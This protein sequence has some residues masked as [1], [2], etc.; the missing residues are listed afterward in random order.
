MRGA[1]SH[2]REVDTARGGRRASVESWTFVSTSRRE[3]PVS[4]DLQ[5]WFA[6]SSKRRARYWQSL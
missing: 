3:K 4:S 6:A 2:H 1:N 5:L